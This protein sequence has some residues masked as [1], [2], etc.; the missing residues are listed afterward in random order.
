MDNLLLKTKLNLPVSREKVIV[1]Q[2]LLD[3][4]N[5]GLLGTDGFARRLTLISAPAGYGKTTVAV[6][7][8]L[9]LGLQM[10]WLTLDEEDNDPVR[11]TGYLV[12]AFQQVD[13][14]IGTRSLEML[15]SP[16]LPQAE[17]LIT[18]LINDLAARPSPLIFALDDYHFIQNSIIH[19]MVG[20]LLEHQ[21]P[22][23]HQVILTREDPL[24]PISR[25]LSR[26]QACEVRQDD[27]RFSSG[28]TAVFLNR[29]MGL[30]L[31]RED[32]AA[33]QR[34]TEGWIAG[35]QLAGLSLQGLP[36]LHG[37]V[38]SFAGSNR[39]ILDYLFEEVYSRQTPEVQEFL[40][41]T[42]ILTRL[43]GGLC[44]S[45]VQ[46]SDSFDL[47]ESLERLNLFI[48]PLDQSRE[49]YRY[50]RL[51]RD[52]LLHRLSIREGTS[53]KSLHLRACEWY[54]AHGF[55]SNAVQHA[56]AAS[57]WKRAREL[58]IELSEDMLKRGEIVTLLTWFKRFP[59]AF[60]RASPQLCLTY[61]WTLILTGRNELAESLLA[62]VESLVQD[63]PQFLGDIASVQ[64]YLARTRGDV[65]GT[66]E[67]S[68]RALELI[69]ET[70]QTARGIVAVNLGIAYWHTG[71]MEEATQALMESQIAA[72]ETGNF[73]VQLASLIFL[74]RVKAVQGEL[75]QAAKMF[76][77]AIQ[78]GK[79][80]PLVA[81]AH[82][83]LGAL[84]YEWNNLS[85]AR[86]H[87]LQGQEINQNSGN[88]EFQVADYM[89]L[90]RLESALGNNNAARGAL[91]MLQ[92]LEQTGQIP[93]P[94]RN[95][96]LA[97]QVETNLR[98]GDLLAAQQL[99]GLLTMDVDAHPFYRFVGLI[100]ER[101]LIAQELKQEAARRLIPK[102]EA[103]DR[104][105]WVYGSIAVRI[106]QAL[107]AEDQESGIRFL[108]EAVK[109]SHQESFLRI[110]ADY[111]QV[112]APMLTEAARR[113]IKPEYIG[114][115]L[116]T[117]REETGRDDSA[118]AIVEQLS[119]RE[120]EVL[121]L[122][123]AGL[124]NR[125]IASKLYLS[126]GT[127]KTHV[128]NICCKLG[129]TNRTQAVVRAKN[130]NLI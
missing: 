69:P 125:E 61:I 92:E 43:T 17:V 46:R 1:R 94:N 130:M 114:R 32:I 81:L 121:R 22:H 62:N 29:T 19:Q 40:V 78:R 51:F 99:A 80:A 103:A 14:D 15:Q 75:H 55:H 116:S 129:V 34:R 109:R 72:Q 53:E 68:Q 57:D 85:A 50:H 2:R 45:V 84:H 86:E 102:S 60:V 91:E 5:D 93:A 47:L 64:A 101:L 49:W 123:A 110:F 95:R 13:E 65:V 30:K 106:L 23:L 89:L 33:L 107:A 117:I 113:G 54:Q 24:L 37:F 28:E 122:V 73:Y 7:W 108:S 66:I 97:I 82:N 56:L 42:S 9:S 41:S 10:L 27:L 96:S 26:G 39:Y 119:D 100:Q 90:A 120:L 58:V 105:G 76:Q 4:L 12:A 36:D 11:F 87:L 83:D 79:T 6:E 16:Q 59:D 124:S 126:P 35:L 20:F 48:V 127:V 77:R 52:L 25:L 112:L 63:E 118:S 3:Q 21:P 31:R 111:G 38:R 88:I 128:H 67:Y 18:P 70:N 74:G 44:D 71:Q 104:A 8:M 98:L 115:I